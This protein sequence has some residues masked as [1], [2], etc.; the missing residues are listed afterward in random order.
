MTTK[1]DEAAM[2]AHPVGSA[3]DTPQADPPT[4]GA[5]EPYTGPEWMT[6]AEC[7]AWLR[8]PARKVSQL[9]KGARPRV[10]AFWVNRRVVRFHRPTV[11]AALTEPERSVGSATTG[12][13][14]LWRR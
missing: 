13:R 8:L 10:R 12:R 7:A 14:A 9:S 5:P 4:A 11:I 3:A 2:E 6:L 1:N